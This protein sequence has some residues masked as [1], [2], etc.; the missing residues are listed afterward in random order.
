MDLFNPTSILKVATKILP[1][2]KSERIKLGIALL[3]I[4]QIIGY[5]V[6]VRNINSP[7]SDKNCQILKT[8]YTSQPPLIS[9]VDSPRQKVYRLRDFYIKTAYNCCCGGKY[10]NDFVDLCALTAC[11]GQG[12]RCLDFEIFSI[13]N[14]PVVAASSLDNFKTKETYNALPIEQV[15]TTINTQ[16]FA[17]GFCPNFNDPMILHFRISS[18]NVEMY[19]KLADAI[20]VILNQRVLGPDYSN[21]YNN[22]NLGAVPISTFKQKIIIFVNSRDAVYKKT[23]LYEYINMTSDTSAFLHLKRYTEIRYT[24]DLNLTNFNKKNMTIV[25]PDLSV[26]NKNSNY[27]TTNDYGC[28]M[29]AMSFQ[30]G[31]ANLTA[32]NNF[33]NV[34]RFAFALKPA[35]L[36]YV[37][38]PATAAASKAA[39]AA[40]SYAP[41]TISGDFYSFQI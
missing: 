38:P 12:V 29:T 11:I 30:N 5:I 7:N 3:I 16:A 35:A 33:F 2:G 20:R 31:D 22:K 37:Q 6:Y 18:T 25:L 28:Q 41:R 14:K 21:E 24:Q 13:D 15:L 9:V 4:A 8:L 39:Q 40:Y 34:A 32:Y 23:K 27:H 10:K 19:N 26:S 36:R 1:V 17:N